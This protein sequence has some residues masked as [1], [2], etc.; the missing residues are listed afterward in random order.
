MKK[1]PFSNLLLLHLLFH[2]SP[3]NPPFCSESFC[4]PVK[5][6]EISQVEVAS[7]H[8][9]VAPTKLE[10]KTPAMFTDKAAQPSTSS[11]FSNPVYSHLSPQLPSALL[12]AP[13]NLEAR[14]AATAVG[15][16][17]ADEHLEQDEGS[18]ILRLLSEGT[19]ESTI[20]VSDYEKVE[21]AEQE[22][23]RLQSLDSGVGGA[24]EVSQESLEADSMTKTADEDEDEREQE[25][26][27]FLKL[28]GGG[29]VVDKGSIQVCSG[30]EQIQ[31]MHN[32]AAELLSLDSGTSSGCG[33]L[34]DDED[35]LTGEDESVLLLS[36]PR[37]PDLRCSSSA[38]ASLALKLPG[39]DFGGAAEMLEKT[40]LMS[41][42][43]PVSRL[44]PS[45]DEYL[46]VR[47]E[48]KTDAEKV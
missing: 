42:G 41:S 40:P 22:R 34:M 18:A 24:G 10:E 15:C 6:I 11:S 28:F 32:D 14:D 47:W 33:Q 31:K 37:A 48:L 29:G 30:Y 45:A 26:K 19:S 3:K 2:Q 17:G 43:R 13:G 39:A 16:H 20:A 4:S 27:D 12:L 44:E 46:P 9:A 25:E 1:R 36:S 23:S 21:R 35:N 8:G 38:L 5:P 7:T